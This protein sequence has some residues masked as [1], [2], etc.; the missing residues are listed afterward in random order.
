MK[1]SNKK[2]INPMGNSLPSLRSWHIPIIGQYMPSAPTTFNH[3]KQNL[4]GTDSILMR[5]F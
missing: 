2:L 1:N 3:K 5:D 4:T